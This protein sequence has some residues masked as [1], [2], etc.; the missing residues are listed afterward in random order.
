MKRKSKRKILIEDYLSNNSSNAVLYR[1][2]RVAVKQK[3]LST[4]KLDQ[5]NFIRS[6]NRTIKQNYYKVYKSVSL[7]TDIRFVVLD[8][9]FEILELGLVSP[10]ITLEYINFV[11]FGGD[12]Y[13][14]V[15]LGEKKFIRIC[16]KPFFGRKV[17]FCKLSSSEDSCYFSR[18]RNQLNIFECNSQG[19]LAAIENGCIPSSIS[20]RRSIYRRVGSIFVK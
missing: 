17:Y 6:F 1:E 20:G 16:F 9:Y 7:D 13:V 15:K 10:S 18:I 8:I 19:E 3:E 5:S 12:C 4:K 2:L 11:F 14:F